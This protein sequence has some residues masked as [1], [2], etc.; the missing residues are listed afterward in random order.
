[1]EIISAYGFPGVLDGKES[2]CDSG[3]LGLVSGSRRSSGEGNDNPLQYSC[4]ENPMDRGALWATVHQVIRIGHNWATNTF[5]F[6]ENQI[7][8]VIISSTKLIKY[9]P[10]YEYAIDKWCEYQKKKAKRWEQFLLLKW[11]LNIDAKLCCE[12]EVAQSCPT[13]CDPMDCSLQRSSVRRIFQARI[14]EWIAISF[15]RGSSWPRDW[16]W[17]SHIVGRR[18]TVWATRELKDLSNYSGLS[19]Y[20]E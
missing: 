18:L 17:V 20:R 10:C 6:M 7:F 5:T 15:S 8:N 16:T 1:M 2:A 4:L 9:Q 13:L 11:F 14:L 19:N 12:R 3:D